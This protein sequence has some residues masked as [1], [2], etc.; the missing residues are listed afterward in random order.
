MIES[1]RGHLEEIGTDYAIVAVGP[2]SIKVM[3]T[4]QTLSLI[5]APANP[6]HLH[7]YIYMREDIIA[8]YGFATR[9]ER[10]LFEQ[11]IGVTGIGPRVA[12]NVLSGFTADRLSAAIEADDAVALTRAPGVGRKTAQRIILEL[13][14]KLTPTSDQSGHGSNPADMELVDALTSLGFSQAQAAT[15]LRSVTTETGLSDEEKLRAAI[16]LLGQAL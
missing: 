3:T 5:G 2:V 11:L 6:V 8:L 1:L 7:T 14:G 10:A 4:T 15:A 13:R 16:R 9:A 12:L